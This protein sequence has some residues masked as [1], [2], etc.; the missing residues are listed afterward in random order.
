MTP[1]VEPE[2]VPAVVPAPEPAQETPGEVTTGHQP[3]VVTFAVTDDV[4]HVES[5]PEAA[6][7]ATPPEATAPEVQP[8]PAPTTAEPTAVTPPAPAVPPPTPTAPAP[9]QPS[10]TDA[11]LNLMLQDKSFRIPYLQRLRQI[12]PSLKFAEQFEAEL[13]EVANPPKPALTEDQIAE[14]FNKIASEKS[15]GHAQLWLHKVVTEPQINATAAELKA[16]EAK[17]QADAKAAKDTALQ[18]QVNAQMDA[19]IMQA[20]KEFEGAFE[21]HPQA[22][23]RAKDAKLNE[24]MYGVLHENLRLTYSEAFTI[25]CKRQGRLATAKPKQQP[26]SKSIPTAPA[27]GTRSEYKPGVVSFQIVEH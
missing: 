20:E 6:I 15:L 8:E 4:S 10:E 18:T 12:N 17:R 9:A 7:E 27:A 26:V 19:E 21:R 16:A 11:Q 13:A 5:A 23:F 22:G 2:P 24:G 14:E 25:A 3:G 1:V